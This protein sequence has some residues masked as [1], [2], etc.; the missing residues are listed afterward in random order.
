MTGRHAAWQGK[1]SEWKKG[2]KKKANSK[3]QMV[4][5][6]AL[7]LLFTSSVFAQ[8]KDLQMRDLFQQD[9]ERFSRFS[10]SFDDIL[11]DYSKNRITADALRLL[12]TTGCDGVIIG[13]VVDY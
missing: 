4:V 12:R 6:T 11:L 5:C 8:T 10:L 2:K 13:P 9:P 7:V 1:V 3:M